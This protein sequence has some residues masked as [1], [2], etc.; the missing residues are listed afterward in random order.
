MQLAATRTNGATVFVDYA[1]TPDA[2][3]TA[4]RALRPHVLGR[5]IAIVGAGGDRDRTKRPLMG[6]AA[7]AHA[8][9]VIVTD[10]NPRTEDPALIRAAVMAGAGPEATEVGDRAEAILRGVDALGPGDALLIMGKGHE[11]GQVIG[12]DVFPFDDAEQASIAV[13]ALDGKI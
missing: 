3:E 6:A 5:I 2:V 4:L 1:H 8:D 7:A 11:R 9:A 12:T 10:D 13:A